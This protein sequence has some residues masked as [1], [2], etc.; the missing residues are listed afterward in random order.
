MSTLVKDTH[1][2]INFLQKKGYSKEQ[3]EGFVEAV[4]D[5]DI[6]KLATKDQLSL[7]ITKINFLMGLN[8]AVFAGIIVLL[9]EKLFV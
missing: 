6:D 9:L 8:V 1:D 3:A 4:K 7:I 5:F 2:L